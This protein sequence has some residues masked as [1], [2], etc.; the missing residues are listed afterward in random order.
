MGALVAMRADIDNKS[1]GSD[2]DLIGTEQEHDI[3]RARLRHVDSTQAALA[4]H[5]AKIKCTDTRR[6]RMQ[7]SQAIP[8]LALRHV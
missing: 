1:A 4:R 7:N 8:V 3:R 2:V 6:C 5:E